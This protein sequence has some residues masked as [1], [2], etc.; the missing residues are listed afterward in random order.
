VLRYTITVQNSAAIAATGVVLTDAVP[1]NTT[2]VANSTRLNGLPV[3]QPDGGV[4]PL[5]SGID[6][7]SS[8]LTPP[9]PGA[10]A[11]TIS[12][13]AT[14]VLQFDLRVDD[15]TPAGT[16]IS[17]QAVV[18]STELPDLLTDG[19]GDPT[20]GPEPTVVVVGDG[21][22]LSITKQVAWSVAARQCP[23]QSSN[24]SCAW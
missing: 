19:D 13:G 24:T 10:G 6:I 2:Y 22:Q 7:S 14:A 23:A 12:P 16:V 15:G 3:G 20:T 8:D 5:A 18:G 17:N 9:L 21:Q 4:P 1:A 11:G